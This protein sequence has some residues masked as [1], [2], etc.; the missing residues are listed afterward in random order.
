MYGYIERKLNNYWAFILA[1]SIEY[2][3]NNV[4]FDDDKTLSKYV[5]NTVAKFDFDE[6]NEEISF[7]EILEI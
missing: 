6:N 3:L 7:E 2:K 5:H 4:S 1:V